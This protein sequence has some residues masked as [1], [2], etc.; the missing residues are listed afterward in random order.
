MNEYFRFF[1]K[2]T[3]FTVKLSSSQGN[4]LKRYCENHDFFF[5][6]PPY[7]EFS[8]KKEHLSVTYYTSGKLVV[9]GKSAYSFVEE[10]LEPNILE[11]FSLTNPL[12]NQNL[13]PHIGSD[14]SGKGDLFGPLCV[15]ALYADKGGIEQLV[16]WGVQDSKTLSDQKITQLA[17]K[18]SSHFIHHTLKLK[19]EKYNALYEKINN[20]NTLLAWCHSK[21]IEEVCEKSGCFDVLVDQFANKYVLEKAMTNPNIRLEQKTKGEED[22]V[23]AAASIIA[24]AEFVRSLTFMKKDFHISFPKGASKQVEQT[25]INFAQEHGK[26]MLNKVSKT[27]FKPIQKILLS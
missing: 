16:S 3:L 19:P 20:L 8:A 25:A 18:I 7:T 21:A 13:T 1:V 2:K 26:E 10:V 5:T 11:D 23:V 14:E 17:E 4:L 6:T 15:T 12:L 27:H 9:Q 24:R 22:V